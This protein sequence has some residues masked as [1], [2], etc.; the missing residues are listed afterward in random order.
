MKPLDKYIADII[1][2]NGKPPTESTIGILNE[3]AEA[4]YR[5]SRLRPSVSSPRVCA[6][7]PRVS[8]P[9]VCVSSPRDCP[10]RGTKLDEILGSVINNH[11]SIL[12]KTKRNNM[13]RKSNRLN[14]TSR[15][16]NGPRYHV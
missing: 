3:Y 11:G 14:K 12:A 4:V 9:R 8:S 16:A 2:R 7:S 6:S 13:A 1:S 5:Q 10:P 15:R